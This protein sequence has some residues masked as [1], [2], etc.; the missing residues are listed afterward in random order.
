MHQKQKCPN[1]NT[2]NLHKEDFGEFCDNC[3]Y[4]SFPWLD[5]G[6]RLITKNRFKGYKSL[7][8]DVRQEIQKRQDRALQIIK[9]AKKI[10]DEDPIT[11][12]NNLLRAIEDV[13]EAVALLIKD[14]LPKT[15]NYSHE[16]KMMAYITSCHNKVKD[17]CLYIDITGEKIKTKHLT[18]DKFWEKEENK[19]WDSIGER[20]GVIFRDGR[21]YRSKKWEEFCKR[22]YHLLLTLAYSICLFIDYIELSYVPS[23]ILIGDGRVITSIPIT[24]LIDKFKKTD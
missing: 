24:R 1:C 9:S 6:L 23:W 19:R 4:E 21:Y 8:E 16:S 18:E 11:S 15:F 3:D 14:T 2:E 5:E 17:N 20:F 7:K 10:E 13:V 12:V 22:E